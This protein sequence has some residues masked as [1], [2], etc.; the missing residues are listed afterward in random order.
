M[1]ECL[2]GGNNVKKSCFH[3]PF[4]SILYLPLKFI[5]IY[6]HL[7]WIMHCYSWHCMTWYALIPLAWHKFTHCL[8][9]FEILSHMWRMKGCTAKSENITAMHEYQNSLLK[10][11]NRICF[12]LNRK[13]ETLKNLSQNH[14]ANSF[15]YY[16]LWII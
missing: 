15:S 6:S 3:M 4:W 13:A 8:N 1:P 16:V 12:V 2:C 7:C 11:G 14:N 9:W 10:P 5:L